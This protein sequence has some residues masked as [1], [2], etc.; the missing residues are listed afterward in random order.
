MQCPKLAATFAVYGQGPFISTIVQCHV[1][2]CTCMMRGVM[3]SRVIHSMAMFI[4]D[5]DTSMLL[6]LVER[7]LDIV[8]VL[9]HATMYFPT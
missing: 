2:Y 3:Y 7:K 8:M 1:A 4:V 5:A 6:S 9:F